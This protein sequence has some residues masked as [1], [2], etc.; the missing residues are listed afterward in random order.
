MVSEDL[1]GRGFVYDIGLF[2]T[3][4][5]I[6]L[7]DLRPD[8]KSTELKGRDDRGSATHRHPS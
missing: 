4:C 5:Y 7:A 3:N 6:R 8:R 2:L 1:T